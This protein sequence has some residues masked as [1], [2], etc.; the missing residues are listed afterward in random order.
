[1]NALL[2]ILMLVL[3]VTGAGFALLGS[4]ALARLNDFFKR[5]HGPSKA[6]TLGVGCVLLASM[7]GFMRWGQGSGHELLIAFF[8]FLTAPVSAHLLVKA[9]LKRWPQAAPKP[10]G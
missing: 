8:L 9:A 5:L 7:L 10:P 1:M 3:L 4:W 6:T 2:D